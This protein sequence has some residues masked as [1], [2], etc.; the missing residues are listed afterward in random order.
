MSIHPVKTITHTFGEHIRFSVLDHKLPVKARS[1]FQKKMNSL[2]A[3]PGD[4]FI[5]I[6]GFI[7][8]EVI[9]FDLCVRF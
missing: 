6:A 4:E 8:I 2:L 1:L 9:F 5:D 7:A 3:Y